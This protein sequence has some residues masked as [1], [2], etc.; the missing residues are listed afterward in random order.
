M[1][2]RAFYP[3]P[4]E[5]ESVLRAFGLPTE[6]DFSAERLANAALSDKKRA[7]GTLTIVVPHAIGGCTLEKIP[8]TEL[9]PIIEAGMRHG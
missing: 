1:M 7:G 5:I 3:N 6:T 4:E 8:V 9:Q 2:A